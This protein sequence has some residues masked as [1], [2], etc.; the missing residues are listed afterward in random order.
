MKTNKFLKKTMMLA[1]LFLPLSML[2]AQEREKPPKSSQEPPTFKKL[3]E[4]MDKNKDGK[5]SLKEVK[6]PLKEDF[7]I[8][9]L[10][11]DGFI[12]KKE[13]EKA[14][15]PNRKGRKPKRKH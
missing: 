15:K 6:G 10:N 14:P 9:D 13:L 4:D 5:L 8:I 12:T 3:L 1:V 11:D 2:I 7:K